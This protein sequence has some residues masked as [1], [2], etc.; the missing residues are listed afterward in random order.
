MPSRS[1]VRFIVVLSMLLISSVLYAQNTVIGVIDGVYRSET[2]PRYHVA[3]WACAYGLPDSIAVHVWAG[4]HF[5]TDATANLASDQAVANSCGSTGT[6]YRFNIALDDFL[7]QNFGQPIYVYGLSPNGGS[8]NPLYN[9]GAFTFPDGITTNVLGDPMRIRTGPT[10]GGGITSIFWR[11]KEFVNSD[12]HGRNFQMAGQFNGVYECYNPTEG[13]SLSDGGPANMSTSEVFKY[14]I[15]SS[16]DF[17][18]G[19]Y[20]AFWLRPGEGQ[21][22]PV[23]GNCGQPGRAA[24]NTT[25]RSNYLF[26][27]EIIVGN[28]G[29]ENVIKVD[30]SVYIPEAVSSASIESFVGYMNRADFPQVLTFDVTTGTAHT[31]DDPGVYPYGQTFINRPLILASADGCHALGIYNQQLNEAHNPYNGG[32]LV[33]HYRWNQ[34]PDYGVNDWS[35][36]FDFGPTN[37]PYNY[38]FTDYLIIGTKQNVIDTMNTLHSYLP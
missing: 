26:Y 37:Y 34:Y 14:T 28:F 35:A 17:Y 3:G 4:G 32:F 24:L 15:L 20:P 21:F 23:Y 22:A 10:M 18:T 38:Y 11:G 12:D 8:N 30:S 36:V 31:V 5:V 29:L 16:N 7:P 27:K 33:G 6:A 9:A 1:I 19:S 13:G 2:Y 25:W